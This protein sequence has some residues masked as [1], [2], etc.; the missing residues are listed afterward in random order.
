MLGGLGSVPLVF[1]GLC[2]GVGVS[3]AVVVLDLDA[4]GRVVDF[5]VLDAVDVRQG[6]FDGARA[7]FS[8][9]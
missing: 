3:D 4:A 8:Y 5:D 2:E 7:Q 6:A 9:E 1:D